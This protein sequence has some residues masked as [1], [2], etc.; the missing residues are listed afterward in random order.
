MG[1]YSYGVEVPLDGS[2]AQ[3]ELC[4][5]DSPET[6]AEVVRVLLSANVSGPAQIRVVVHPLPRGQDPFA[7][8]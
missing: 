1:S 7:G 6:V 5:C 4:R 8:Q 3:Y 2:A